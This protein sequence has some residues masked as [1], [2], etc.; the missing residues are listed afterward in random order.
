MSNVQESLV[1]VSK[2]LYGKQ[3]CTEMEVNIGRKRLLFRWQ[4]GQLEQHILSR[5]AEGL[6]YLNT[7]QLNDLCEL[8]NHQ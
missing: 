6:N 4:A 8:L 1:S 2:S 5:H 7:A 3:Y